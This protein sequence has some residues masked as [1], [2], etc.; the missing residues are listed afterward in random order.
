MTSESA[1]RWMEMGLDQRISWLVVGCALGYIIRMLQEIKTEV[2]EVDELLTREKDDGGFTRLPLVLD[3]M[4]LIL[5]ALTIWSVFRVEGSV[6]RSADADAA[7]LAQNDRIEQIASCNLE[8]TETTIK[9][10]NE[11]TEYTVDQAAANVDVLES[12]LAYLRLVLVLPPVSPAQQRA[13]LEEYVANLDA[14]V[15]VTGKARV[16]ADI[17]AYPTN[18]ELSD[19]LGDLTISDSKERENDTRERGTK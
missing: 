15:A 7:N 2:H 16:K 9:A 13:S 8:F 14:Y 18:K 3:A 17:Y 12:Q 11:R 4:I 19:C 5:F 6:E 10:L 1:R